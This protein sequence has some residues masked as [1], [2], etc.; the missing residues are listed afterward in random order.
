MHP[1]IQQL[2]QRYGIV[3]EDRC[4]GGHDL[5]Q[6]VWNGKTLATKHLQAK[7]DS[8]TDQYQFSE[9]PLSDHDFLHEIG[10]WVVAAPEQKDLPEYGLGA[11]AFSTYHFAHECPEV[12]DH[13]EATIQEFLTQLLCVYWGKKYNL[14]HLLSSEPEWDIGSWDNY[15]NYKIRE[16]VL[17]N[18]G[19]HGQVENFW[20]AL[21]RFQ[22]LRDQL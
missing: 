11:V 7:Y 14:S 20:T 18:R 19:D 13:K 17:L 5:K 2:A 1:V 12:V 10:H 16:V 8:I 6:P 15:L 21:I 4:C 22:T 3:L 9:V